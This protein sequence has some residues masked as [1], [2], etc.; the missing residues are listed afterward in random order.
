MLAGFVIVI[1]QNPLYELTMLPLWF[2]AKVIVERD[3]NAVNVVYLFLRTAARG[4][5]SSPMGRGV[6][7]P[8][9][10]PRAEPWPGHGVM[11]GESGV[12]ERSGEIY[13]PYVGHISDAGRAAAGRFRHGDGPCRAAWPSRW[14]IPRCGTLGSA[15][16]Y[17][18][19]RN[20][21]DDNVTISTHLIRHPDVPE[22]PAA[23]FRSE[24]ASKL[25]QA[26]RE[27]IL[28]GR[29]FR[30][31]YFF[32]LVVSPATCPGQ[33]WKQDRTVPQRTGGIRRPQCASGT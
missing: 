32:S 20:I 6:G 25:D 10:N 8:Q 31:D 30:N 13:L 11:R 23:R 7:Q 3:Y 5:D 16:S 21:A 19:F 4:V 33:G 22:L 14:R 29:L 17:T 15:I 12:S 28:N 26:Y 27:R 2:G 18:L 9:P 24:F 1:M